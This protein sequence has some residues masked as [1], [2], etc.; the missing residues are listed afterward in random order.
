MEC[1]AAGVRP[2]S[3]AMAEYWSASYYVQERL[4]DRKAF[5][6]A[7]LAGLVEESGTV[8]SMWS[9]DPAANRVVS[10]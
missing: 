9:S 2:Y 1:C 7:V 3:P 4:T 6:L 5:S 8:D 10:S